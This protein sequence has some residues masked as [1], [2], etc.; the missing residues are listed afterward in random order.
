M[1]SAFPLVAE[2][3]NLSIMQPFPSKIEEATKKE[4]LFVATDALC[5]GNQIEGH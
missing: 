5:K 4:K 2:C 1:N 3:F